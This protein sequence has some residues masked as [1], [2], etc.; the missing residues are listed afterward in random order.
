MLLFSREECPRIKSHIE[1]VR[2][3]EKG[4]YKEHTVDRA[5]LHNNYFFRECYT[6]VAQL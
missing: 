2:A 6:F 4:L 3:A 1:V 5:P